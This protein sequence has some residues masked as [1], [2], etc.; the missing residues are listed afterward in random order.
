MMFKFNHAMLT[1]YRETCLAVESNIF[2]CK[3][4]RDTASEDIGSAKRHGPL[5]PTVF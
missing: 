3:T 4:P 5:Y 2:N 1:P